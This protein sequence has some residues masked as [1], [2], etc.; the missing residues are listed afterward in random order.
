MQIAHYDQRSECG[1]TERRQRRCVLL[2]SGDKL[3]LQRPLNRERL[4]VHYV[5]LKRVGQPMLARRPMPWRARRLLQRRRRLKPLGLRSALCKP[6]LSDGRRMRVW[7]CSAYRLRK[8]QRWLLWNCSGRVDSDGSTSLCHPGLPIARKRTCRW[9]LS[10]Q[11]EQLLRKQRRFDASRKHSSSLPR[12]PP[13]KR[14]VKK[15]RWN[16]SWKRSRGLKRR[17]FVRCEPWSCNGQVTLKRSC[18]PSCASAKPRL[19]QRRQS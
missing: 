15:R 8:Q 13:R 14:Q 6:Q 11:N 19:T 1:R 9:N 2:A 10:P 5:L 16:F 3:K 17:L 4:R 18:N 12:K 7:R